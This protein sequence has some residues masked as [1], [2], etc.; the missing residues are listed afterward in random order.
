MIHQQT[1]E[2][3]TKGRGTT[4]ITAEVQRVV[5][6]VHDNTWGVQIGADHGLSK[7]TALYAR[8]GYMRNNG[9]ATMSWPGVAVS[10]PGTSQT[11]AVAG[12]THRF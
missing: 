5:R 12:M 8:G 10:S 11:L 7:R 1:L 3:R 4:D 6:G 9:T 2:F